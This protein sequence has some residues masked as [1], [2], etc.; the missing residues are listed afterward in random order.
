MNRFPSQAFLLG[1]VVNTN[2][3]LSIMLSIYLLFSKQLLKKDIPGT[4]L[5]IQVKQLCQSPTLWGKEK[6]ISSRF[7]FNF[8]V[9]FS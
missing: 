5:G 7:L 1:E 8:C 4:R 6:K 2:F 9:Y 3:H